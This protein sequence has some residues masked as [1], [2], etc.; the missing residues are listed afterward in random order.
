MGT[1]CTDSDFFRSSGQSL[2]Q[3]K[4][5]IWSTVILDDLNTRARKVIYHVARYGLHD[6]SLVQLN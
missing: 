5:H 1:A 3:P 6:Y 4:V 2:Q